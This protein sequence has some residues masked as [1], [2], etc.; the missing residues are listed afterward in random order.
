MTAIG[1][2]TEGE[3]AAEIVSSRECCRSSSIS[4]SE[5]TDERGE[6]GEPMLAMIDVESCQELRLVGRVRIFV[7]WS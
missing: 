4:S 6:S 5:G 2:E 3:H 1:V 7:A